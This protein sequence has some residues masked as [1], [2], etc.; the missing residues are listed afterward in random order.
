MS[1]KKIATYEEV[2]LSALSQREID[3]LAFAKAVF[4]LEEASKAVDDYDSFS[5]GLKFHQ[6]L[7][8]FIQAAVAAAGR[9]SSGFPRVSS[10]RVLA[11][12][13]SILS[14]PISTICGPL[15]KFGLKSA[16]NMLD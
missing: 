14:D 5:S 3:G 9:G 2:I 13:T 16:Q 7:V 1:T 15:K 8:T 4:R 11:S 10:R 12:V 6:M